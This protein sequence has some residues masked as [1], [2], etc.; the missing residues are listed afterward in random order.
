MN[1]SAWLGWQ[2]LGSRQGLSIVRDIAEMHDGGFDLSES[3]R[4][5]FAALMSLPAAV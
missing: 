2:T 3:D 1:Q 4:G 5:G